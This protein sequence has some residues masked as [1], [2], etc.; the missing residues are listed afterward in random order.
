M[1]KAVHTGTDQNMEYDTLAWNQLV[2]APL[3]IVVCTV[4][5]A[6][7]ALY[8]LHSGLYGG[9]P[10]MYLVLKSRFTVEATTCLEQYVLVCTRLYGNVPVCTSM[11]WYIPRS[12]LVHT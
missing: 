7:D 9:C 11:Y 12:G 3:Y 6:D 1:Y 5:T 4:W 8:I 10:S 2:N